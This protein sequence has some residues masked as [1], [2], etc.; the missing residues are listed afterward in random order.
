M[1]SIISGVYRIRSG[2][3][4]AYVI[5]GDEGVTLVDTLLPKREEL[6]EESLSEIGRSLADLAAIVLTHSH[7][8]H[9]GSAAAVEKASGPRVR[10]GEGRRGGARR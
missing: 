10:I 9:A 7:A 1:E 4:S 8:D 2:Y 5:D 3:V 6:I